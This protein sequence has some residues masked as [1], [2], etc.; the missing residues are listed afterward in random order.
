MHS[1]IVSMRKKESR[2]LLSIIGAGALMA[3]VPM[4][5]CHKQLVFKLAVNLSKLTL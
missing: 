3:M 1:H 2:L 4:A 5:T